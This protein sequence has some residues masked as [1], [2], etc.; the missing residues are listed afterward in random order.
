MGACC[1]S[2]PP[3]ELNHRRTTRNTESRR[4]RSVEK[5]YGAHPL[6][7]AVIRQNGDYLETVLEEIED[8]HINELD[9]L[10]YTAAQLC[11]LTGWTDGLK[12]LLAKDA[13]PF[14]VNP[15]GWSL[16]QDSIAL[17]QGQCLFAILD[18]ISK[19]NSI[20]KQ[21]CLQYLHVNSVLSELDDFIVDINWKV[22]TWVPFIAK[23]CPKDVIRIYKKGC[24]IRVDTNIHE[25]NQARMEWEYNPR[26]MI[27]KSSEKG[28]LDIYEKSLNNLGNVDHIQTYMLDNIN[29]INQKILTMDNNINTPNFVSIE[30]LRDALLY[31]VIYDLEKQNDPKR[32][33]KRSTSSNVLANKGNNSNLDF[34][35]LG[36]KLL[37]HLNTQT[38]KDM[39]AL[40]SNKTLAI[41]N[42]KL[43]QSKSLFGDIKTAKINDYHC[44]LYEVIFLIS[45]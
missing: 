15:H 13:S 40:L 3:I 1:T 21:A 31:S 14:M 4:R 8:I 28:Y 2:S 44:M 6:H 5:T 19:N 23:Y 29:D 20:L 18:H 16:I 36:K 43:F 34:S 42:L 10:G 22:S 33:N 39:K 27:F 30:L 37:K 12:I 41:E 26:L 17:S 45:I 7:I 35:K 9:D 32:K 38:K 25:F 11:V 24:T